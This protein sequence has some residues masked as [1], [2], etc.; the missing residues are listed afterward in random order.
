M[1]DGATSVTDNVF[2]DCGTDAEWIAVRMNELVQ[3]NI[4]HYPD[5]PLH[6]FW[7]QMS[8]KL[9]HSVADNVFTAMK[10]MN[11]RLMPWRWYD[12]SASSCIICCLAIAA[13]LSK[14]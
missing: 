3:K 4:H 12:W 1:I 14:T 6:E 5:I 9:R 2:F 8:A 11:I 13:S 10:N 7:K